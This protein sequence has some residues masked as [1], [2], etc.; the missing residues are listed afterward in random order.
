MRV[1]SWFGCLTSSVIFFYTSLFWYLLSSFCSLL[2]LK[3]QLQLTSYSWAELFALIVHIFIANHPIMHCVSICVPIC[4]SHTLWRLSVTFVK[5]ESP[6][7]QNLFIHL[8]K[9]PAGIQD[10]LSTVARQHLSECLHTSVAP[11][12]CLVM[13][14]LLHLFSHLYNSFTSYHKQVISLNIKQ[15]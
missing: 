9:R 2:F 11:L 5:C 12:S 14:S 1:L 6:E 13:K 15:T 3:K 4:P 10:P 7:Q 8:L